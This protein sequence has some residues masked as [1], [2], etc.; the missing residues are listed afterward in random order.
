[1]ERIARKAQALRKTR[2]FSSLDEESLAWLAARAEEQC[3]SAGEMLFF[4]GEP[5]TGMFVVMSGTIRAFQQNTDGREQVMHVDH[6]GATI[7]DVPVFDDGPY[8]ASAIAEA[9]TK[10]LF[11]HKSDVRELCLKHPGFALGALKLMAERVR[12]HAQLVNVI[13]LHEVGQRL[14]LLLLSEAAKVGR[15]QKG[16]VDFKLD[17]S[18][19]EMATHIGTVRDVVS[20]ALGRLQQLGLVTLQMRTVTIP[21]VQALRMYAEGQSTSTRARLHF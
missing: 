14:S 13:S 1:M 6:A 18:N 19:H 21:D 5:A 9:D 7:A 12:K 17:L 11:L 3:L 4:S 10:I 20:R 8:P 16:S 2:L 15:G